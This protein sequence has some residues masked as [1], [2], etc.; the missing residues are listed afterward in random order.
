MLALVLSLG[1]SGF[2]SRQGALTILLRSFKLLG[3]LGLLLLDRPKRLLH[4]TL[5]VRLSLKLIMSA[6]NA[7]FS[8][9]NVLGDLYETTRGL[10]KEY[11]LRKLKC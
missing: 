8:H 3:Q 9:K 11:I 4:L 5:E 10:H 1:L 6:P 2:K 7:F